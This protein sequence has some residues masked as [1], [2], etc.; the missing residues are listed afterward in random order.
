M[1]TAEQRVAIVTDLPSRELHT[2]FPDLL[3][4]DPFIN[5]PEGLSRH[6]ST[7]T[8]Q[9]VVD[10]L[11]SGIQL[12]T[13]APGVGEIATLYEQALLNA[14]ITDVL[15]VSVGTK[16]STGYGNAI[17]IAQQEFF[18]RAHHFDSE[19]VFDGT[20][21][22]AGHA[23]ELARKGLG[24]EEIL[25]ELKAMQQRIVVFAYLDSP[26]FAGRGGRV[27]KEIITKFLARAGGKGIVEMDNNIGRS[28]GIAM[29][30]KNGLARLVEAVEDVRG[31]RLIE[32]VVLTSTPIGTNTGEKERRVN[33][34]Q[35]I[36]EI[37]DNL[38]GKDSNTQR[39]NVTITPTLS[40]HLGPQAQG[41]VVLFERQK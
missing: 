14:G 33:L 1:A 38:S 28:R 11:L 3:V 29:T 39:E 31:G 24:V 23:L 35:E 2:R 15:H 9:L 16:L 18:E 21:I 41:V 27:E 6:D 34:S 19:T 8:S 37:Y 10:E 4:T 30:R 7:L 25:F 22:M 26:E 36:D 13:A 17:Y 5:T 20:G 32:R 40:V 12:S